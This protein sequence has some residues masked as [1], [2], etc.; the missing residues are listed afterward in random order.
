MKVRITALTGLLALGLAGPAAAQ[1]GDPP[2]AP[3]NGI[4]EELIRLLV[5]TNAISRADAERLIL[6]LREQQQDNRPPAESGDVR[7]IHVP[8]KEKREM[9]E[10][11]R[12]EVMTRAREEN[13]AQP[14]TLPGWTRRIDIFGDLRLRGE[15]QFFDESN[16][17]SFVDYAEINQGGPY[18]ING[19][20]NPPFMNN[21]EDRNRARIRLRLGMNVDIAD[22]L[23]MGLRFATGNLRDPVSTNETFDNDFNKMQFLVDRAYMQY[24]PGD[25]WR[26]LLGRTPN[27]WFSTSLVWDGD[28]GF[29]G[30]SATWTFKE[31]SGPFATLGAYTLSQTD[32]DFPTLSIAKEES[33]YRFLLGAQVGNRFRFTDATSATLALAY[34]HYGNVEGELSEPCQAPGSEYSCYTDD[35]RATNLQKGNTLFAIRQ[36]QP[37]AGVSDPAQYQYFGLASEFRELNLTAQLDHRLNDR[38]HLL[39]TLD[40]VQNLAYDADDI[41]ALTPVNNFGENG[42]PFDG[43]DQGYL[44]EAKVGVPEVRDS[45]QWSLAAGYKRLESDAVL[46]AFTDSDFH[47]G[48]TNAKGFY[49]EGQ[50]GV[51]DD[52]WMA[53]NWFSTSE[54]SGPPFAVD[55]LQLD[56]NTRF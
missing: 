53:L 22:D 3:E 52:T 10:Q 29:D 4:T 25:Q 31:D 11:I 47:L 13:W 42:D 32:S 54:I 46:D 14:D 33:R 17:P 19:Q 18:N 48:G 30:A 37:Q 56:I 6:K 21:I 40:Y 16:S 1:Q 28:L 8:E 36:I 5:D 24:T 7:V 51:L 20:L 50:W 26:F 44:L 35:T 41:E 38:H 27:P 15:G 12:Q 43:G 23:D 49:L 39:L 2:A 9:R 45:G 34:Y 55:V